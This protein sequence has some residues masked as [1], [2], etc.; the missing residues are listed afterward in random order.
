MAESLRKELKKATGSVRTTT[1]W[2]Q[3]VDP[4]VVYAAP[5]TCFDIQTVGVGFANISESA[6]M[7]DPS[8]KLPWLCLFFFSQIWLNLFNKWH[9]VLYIITNLVTCF[10]F[11][12]FFFFRIQLWD[13]VMHNH[14]ATNWICDI[15][16][17][18][19][20]LGSMSPVGRSLQKWLLQPATAWWTLTRQAPR[21]K[22][23]HQGVGTQRSWTCCTLNLL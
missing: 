6:L 19:R 8:N 21:T 17:R 4:L 18:S 23:E 5:V 14:H 1:G 15:S 22:A 10:F 2:L 7:V 3:P 9:D 16:S 12:F 20:I 11:F 13:I